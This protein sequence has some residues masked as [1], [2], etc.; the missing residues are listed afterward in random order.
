MKFSY[1]L[2]ALILITSFDS[3]AQPKKDLIPFDKNVKLGKLPNGLTYYIRK[4][5]KPEHKAELRLVVNAGSVL[6]REDQRGIAHF[7]EHMAFNGTAHFP[8]NELLSYLQKAGVRFGADLNATTSFDFT[9][10]M[11]PI[12]S[13]DETVLQ[14][15]YQVLRD[16]AGGLLLDQAEIEKERGVILEEKR[17]RQ[18]AAQRTY[19][20]YLPILTN[21][22]KYGQRIPI[23]MEEVIKTAPRKAFIDFYKDWYRP[24]NMAVIVV[25]DIDVEKSFTTITSMFGG[26]SNPVNA[27][28]RPASIPIN[29]HKENE[30]TI[31]TDPENTN[32]LL[33]IF[34]GME[35]DA[36]ESTWNDFEDDLF[37]Q[38][39]SRL[40]GARLQEQMLSAKSPVSYAN[41][42]L[43]GS[44]LRGYKTATLFGLV[45]DD[46]AASLKMLI[47]EILKVQQFGFN[48]DELDRVKKDILREYEKDLS[49]KDKR[50]S[51]RYVSEYVEH[52]LNKTPSPGIE[53]EQQ[54][55]AKYLAS[56]KVENLNTRIKRFNLNQPAFIL[57]NATDAM[58]NK[59]TKEELLK[60]FA[61]AKQ[62]K[63]EAKVEMKV[64]GDLIEALPPA[65]K[66]ISTEANKDLDAKMLT[67]SNGIKVIYKKTN[68]KNDEIV[69]R[70]SQWGGINNLDLQDVTAAKYF[71]IVNN[72]GLGKHRANDMPKLLNGVELNAFMNVM[73]YQLSLFGNSSAKDFEKLLQV[74]HLKLTQPNFDAEDFDGN[75]E[76]FKS[77]V[78][79]LIKNPS[80]RFTDTVNKFKA[81]NN[82]RLAGLPIAD[83]VQALQLSNVKE[84]YGKLTSNLNGAL[85]VFVGNIDEAA[86]AGL[87]EKYIASIPTKEA[88]VKLQPEN[89][90]KSVS[91]KNSIVI[92]GGKE[93]KSEISLFYYGSLPDVNDKDNLSFNL[94]TDLLQMK[95]NEKLREEMGSTYAP[96]VS[97]S[98]VRPPIGTFNLNLSVSA[99]PDNTEKI[100]TAFDGLITDI[101]NNKLSDEDMVKVKSQ[102]IK[103]FETMSSTNNY[104]S[105][106]LERQYLYGFDS[107]NISAY[108]ESVEATSKDDI[109]N[110]AKKYLGSC[111]I[112]K[113]VMNPE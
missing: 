10:Y 17:M 86:V 83:E 58:K 72:L 67:L 65:G 68:F 111:N 40:F 107:K 1:C 102:K 25:G 62:Q 93:N 21:N 60:A 73:P 80:Y 8:K 55:I 110:V 46:P 112:L 69:F 92:K 88:E 77:Q 23:G 53:A 43:K 5:S 38:V 33:T 100:I 71:S 42:N 2:L 82:K 89:I 31:I 79:G 75:K 47:A 54:F 14:N 109:V 90:I 3:L 97:S 39:V 24:N 22:S 16:W 36:G 18:N 35:K 7:L 44:F 81:N 15:G 32:N 113:A 98:I 56:L 26:L 6:E 9:L 52:F 95:A 96:R 28:V 66:V 70:V 101:I 76:N 94:L 64:T 57:F 78:A 103:S 34:L 20:Q 19:A 51:E 108:K 105:S 74:I 59:A 84:L 13:N 45:K 50:E 41:I 30:A 87:L 29:W 27:P 11:L 37:Q 85:F 49:E 48:N 12:P 99:L 63:V 106:V 61:N 4:N 91:G 104:W